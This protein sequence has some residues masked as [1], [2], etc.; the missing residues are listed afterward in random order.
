MAIKIQ[1]FLC[2]H[3]DQK[4]NF[5]FLKKTK[6]KVVNFVKPFMSYIGWVRFLL[7][8]LFGIRHITT[9][10]L[11]MKLQIIYV[12]SYFNNQIYF[13]DM[14]FLIIHNAKKFR[15]NV[16][17]AGITYAYALV[18]YNRS[19]YRSKYFTNFSR[20]IW[21]LLQSL[22]LFVAFIFW[23]TKITLLKIKIS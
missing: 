1:N 13:L 9:W 20:N 12:I 3:S 10:N 16:A 11:L 7:C 6:Q 17:A 8:M 23:Y 18:A 15:I 21:H 14:P 2:N 5:L 22:C 19:W 4:N